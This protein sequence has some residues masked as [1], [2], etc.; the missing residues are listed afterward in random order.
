MKKIFSLIVIA[1]IITIS[2]SSCGS[3]K[4]YGQPNTRTHTGCWH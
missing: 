1:V 2:V 4:G 3:N